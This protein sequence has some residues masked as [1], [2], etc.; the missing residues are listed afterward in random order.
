MMKKFMALIIALLFVFSV[1]VITFAEEAPKASTAGDKK[2]SLS[3]TKFCKGQSCP[4]TK[5]T[6]VTATAKKTTSTNKKTTQTKKKYQ[7]K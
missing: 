3:G 2:Q 4:N 1:S 5:D 7:A 6:G